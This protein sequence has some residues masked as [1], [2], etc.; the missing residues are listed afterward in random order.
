MTYL[1]AVND[2][3]HDFDF[4]HGRW[5]VHNRRLRARLAGC[6]DWDEFEATNTCKPLLGGLGNLDEFDSEWAGTGA[7]RLLGMTLRLFSPHTRQW[8]IHWAS[9]RDGILETPVV[10]RFESGVGLFHSREQHAG[11]HVLQRF[12]WTHPDP[13]HALWEQ[14]WSVD[15]G[16]S[17]ETNWTM[18]MA[19]VP[20]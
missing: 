14:A 18:H 2:G 7:P 10:G 11:R 5:H 15:G 20:A 6:A 19:R 4:L 13:A 17:W 8:S 3:R 1:H 12:R 16:D 9:N